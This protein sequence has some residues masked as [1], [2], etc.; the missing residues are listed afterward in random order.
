MSKILS[1]HTESIILSVGGAESMILSTHA[2]SL[3]LSAPPAESMM[4]S[5]PQKHHYWR[6]FFILQTCFFYSY[7]CLTFAT[8]SQQL[9]E[10]KF[11]VSTIFQI[12][13]HSQ[14][15]N[16]KKTYEFLHKNTSF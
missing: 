7:L 8:T 10:H 16:N 15:H 11:Y 2:E 4:L 14:K 13:E 9:C 6:V 1:S 3:G 5:A 12:L